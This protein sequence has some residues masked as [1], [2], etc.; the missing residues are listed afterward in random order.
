MDGEHPP[1][2]DASENG[3]RVLVTGS[4]SGVGL[5]TAEALSGAGWQVI[6]HGPDAERVDAAAAGI[7]SRVPNADVEGV[8]GDLSSQAAVRQMATTIEDRYG[9][10]DVLVNNAAAVFDHWS[11]NGDGV[12]LTFA[13]NYVAVYLLTRLLLP[14]IGRSDDGRI[15]T[16]ASEAHRSATLDFDDLQTV[17]E[18]ERFKA[19]GRSKLADLLFTYELSR[20]VK[21]EEIAVVAMHPRTVKTT[22]FRPRNLVERIV[23]AIL[24]LKAD[25][26]QQGA[27][28]AVWLATSDEAHAL[29]GSYVGNRQA[30]ESSAE[31]QDPETAARLWNASAKITGL[32]P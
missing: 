13:V 10:L 31:S 22:L 5:A 7:R 20:R 2:R 19:Y 12:E 30:I 14:T 6:V 24:K 29:H 32:E 27:D 4:T 8:A 28:T 3:R 26:P 17:K 1:H 16:V 18:Y 9:T 25:S 15:V 21:P 23:M 11:I